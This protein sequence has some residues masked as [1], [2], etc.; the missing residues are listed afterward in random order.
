MLTKPPSAPNKGKKPQ[1]GGKRPYVAPKIKVLSSEEDLNGYTI[2]DVIMPLPGRDVAYPG[3]QLGE[4]YK[5]F[6]KLDGLDPDNLVHAQR[7][8]AANALVW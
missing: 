3:G 1:K 7:C 6:L 8:V 4:R 2:F 5:E